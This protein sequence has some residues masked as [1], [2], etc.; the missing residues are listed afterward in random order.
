MVINSLK[1]PITFS[2]PQSPAV[3]TGYH[4]SPWLSPP[5]STKVRRSLILAKCS[6]LGF[7]HRWVKTSENRRNHCEYFHADRTYICPT[8]GENTRLLV[9]TKTLWSHGKLNVTPVSKRVNNRTNS[10][11][12]SKQQ[13]LS[14]HKV[15]GRCIGLSQL[16]RFCVV[17]ATSRRRQSLWLQSTVPGTNLAAMLVMANVSQ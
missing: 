2:A 17:S 14:S 8:F 4:F 12:L 11:L 10:C 3:V 1:D 7:F 5:S 15:S 6:C 16:P 9:I 13:K